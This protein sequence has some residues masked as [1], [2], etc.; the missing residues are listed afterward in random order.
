EA[1]RLAETEEMLG[2]R[3]FLHPR[4]RGLL[5]VEGQLVQ[6]DGRRAPVVGPQVKVVVEH[7]GTGWPCQPARRISVTPSRI[8]VSTQ[9]TR[10]SLTSL[11]LNALIAA[12][13]SLRGPALSKTALSKTLPPCR[14][15]S[16]TIN[17]CGASMGSAASK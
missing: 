9:T 4:R 2:H 1:L 6:V 16:A 13:A 15:L 7:R 14:V 10:G 8:V 17:P 5:A 12:A 3:Q 11:S